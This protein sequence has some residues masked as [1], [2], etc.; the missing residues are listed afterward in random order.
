MVLEF[1]NKI[2]KSNRAK[3]QQASKAKFWCGCCDRALVGEHGKCPVCKK[4]SSEK[5][6]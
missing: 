4:K 1:E 5:R 2:K 3:S 6:K